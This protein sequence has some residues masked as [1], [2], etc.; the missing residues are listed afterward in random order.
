M[1]K[2]IKIKTPIFHHSSI[3]IFLRD[4]AATEEF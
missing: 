2:S 4:E 3:L 1:S